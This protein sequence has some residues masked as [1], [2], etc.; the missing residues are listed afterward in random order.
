ML[1]LPPPPFLTHPH[2]K[3]PAVYILPRPLAV[4]TTSS[5]KRGK[6][7]ARYRRSGDSA[8]VR[9]LASHQCGLGSIPGSGV[10]CGL[11]LLLVLALPRGFFSGFFGFSPIT[12]ANIFIFPVRPGQRSRM[13]TRFSRCGFLSV[14]AITWRISFRGEISARPTGPKSQPGFWKKSS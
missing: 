4:I 6:Q 11:S 5:K 10:I 1:W 14:G 13:R 2:I 9:A 12:K 7:T 8:V 3:S